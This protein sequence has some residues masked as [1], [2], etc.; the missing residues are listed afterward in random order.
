MCRNS[1]LAR[2]AGN[3]LSME[4]CRAIATGCLDRSGASR[5]N[6]PLSV[7]RFQSE[8][9][10]RVTRSASFNRIDPPECLEPV[11]ASLGAFESL[12]ISTSGRVGRAPYT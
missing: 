3:S 1:Q 11:S 6:R 8:Y 4:M 9:R 7:S 5:E 12:Q 10:T 2:A